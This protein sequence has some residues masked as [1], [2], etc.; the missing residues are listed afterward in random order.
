MKTRTR[1]MSPNKQISATVL[2]MQNVRLPKLQILGETNK[3]SSRKKK[4]YCWRSIGSASLLL[5]YKR[6]DARTIMLDILIQEL[7]TIYLA[8][9]NSS[10]S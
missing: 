9:W 2:Y 1:K 3:A 10:L 4:I 7:A 6:M 8:S 5:T